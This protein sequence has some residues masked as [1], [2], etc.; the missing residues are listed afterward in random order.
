MRLTLT[1]RWLLA[2]TLTLCL[3]LLVTGVI[4][5]RTVQQQVYREVET[6]GEDVTVAL[7]EMISQDPT[8][9]RS[10]LLQPALLRFTRQM[11]NVERASVVNHTLGILADSDPKLVGHT[12]TQSALFRLL[13]DGQ[14]QKFEYQHLGKRYLRL[15]VPVEGRYDPLRKS[16]VI[17]ALSLDLRLS[18]AEGRIRETFL[19]TMAAMFVF[20][21]L[22]WVAQY[23]LA[24]RWLLGPLASL[25]ASALRLGGG[26]FAVRAPVAAAD[27]L[28]Q[29]AV[30][31]NTM[32]AHVED[33][34]RALQAEVEVRQ[35]AQAGLA[36]L[37]QKLE[38]ANREL[39]DFDYV[40]S[41]DLKAPL[42]AISSLA[43]WIATDYADKLDA[44]GQENL[45]LLLGRVKRMHN[46]IEGVLRYSRVARVRE[47][48]EVVD[49]NTLVAEVVDGLAPPPHVTIHAQD[50]LPDVLVERTRIAQVFQNLLSN[51]VKYMDKP[52][53]EIRVGC[54][55]HGDSW[56]FSVSD[57][58]PGIEQRHFEKIFQ[59]F[60]TL[61]PRDEFESTG[62]GLTVAKKA[63]EIHGGAIWVESE[64]G[65]GSTFLFTLPRNAPIAPQP[66]RE[67]EH[68]REDAYLAC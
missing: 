38:R 41:H 16:N 24:R 37:L 51:A 63:I 18:E 7:T 68:D 66:E 20:L 57:N 44:E 40:V 9:F 30:A 3:I 65:K 32:A 52:E 22:F 8:L 5:Y 62:I 48:Q 27:E 36:D 29:V 42:R 33:T 59:I 4:Q 23:Y 61:K 43:G 15:S 39:S 21:L 2:Q 10:Q 35:K 53:G 13:S 58:G 49:L 56:R 17:G 47:Q 46:L 11:A 25:R 60:Q 55:P 28:G 26:D 14:P 34:T 45:R 19:G 67:T 64:V 50:R 54:E 31:F 6:S 12:T 1:S